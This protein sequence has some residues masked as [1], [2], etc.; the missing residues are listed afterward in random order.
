MY[1][2]LFLLLCFGIVNG[3]YSNMPKIRQLQEGIESIK[4]EQ[5]GIYDAMDEIET[6]IS[7]QIQNL[8]PAPGSTMS[9]DFDGF[10]ERLTTLEETVDSLKRY[11]MAEKRKDIVLKSRSEDAIDKIND[12]VNEATVLVGSTKVDISKRVSEFEDTLK[13][14][15]Q[16][17]QRNMNVEGVIMYGGVGTCC[18][19]GND[20]C[21]VA[22]SECRKG[23]CQCEPGYSYDANAQQCVSTCPTYGTTFQS[24]EKRVIRGN[25]DDV[26]KDIPFS[27]CKQ[28]C[29]NAT[30]FVCRSIDYF[31]SMKEC[32][33][34][35]V[36]KLEAEDNWE[37][38]GIGD[39]FQRD[40]MNG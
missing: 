5:T 25:N 18:S 35:S 1:V 8:G 19:A 24:V 27:E 14:V 37:Y 10:D 17:A 39:H 15:N 32:Y 7:K 28:C 3:H 12:K 16:S 21:A 38:N 6:D 2:S 36:T 23:R 31:Q 9:T 30:D 22:K 26:V 29:L 33:L 11:L 34:S 4:K 13:S 40:C 20:A